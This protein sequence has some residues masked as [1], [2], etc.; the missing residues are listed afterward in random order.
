[1]AHPE[2]PARPW[3]FD[4]VRA[5]TPDGIRPAR[6]VVAGASVAAVLGPSDPVP[7]G[8]EVIRGG[9]HL[10]L[11]AFCDAHC[12]FLFVGLR[13]IRPDLEP[14][15]S[16][17]EALALLDAASRRSDFPDTL[18]AEAWDESTWT[19][20]RRP[21]T[22]E[23]LDRVVPDRPVVARRVCTHFATANSAALPYFEGEA[24][25]D[26]ATG[27]LLEGPAMR[28]GVRL[29]G[30]EGERDR[31]LDAAVAA[32]H[33]AGIGTV[34]DLSRRT[35][36]S[37]FVAA[38]RAGR[39]PLRVRFFVKHEEWDPAPDWTEA[40]TPAAGDGVRVVGVKLFAD[41]SFGARSAAVSEPFAGTTE[42]GQLLWAAPALTSALRRI[43]DAGLLPAVHA[44]G[45][46]AVGLV[47]GA[48]TEA[49][50]SRIRVEHLE[51]VDEATTHALAGV[52]AIAS[53]Q[54]NFVSRWAGS[55]G[56]YEQVL[57]PERAR[58][59][60]PFRRVVD[61]GLPLAFGSDS[62]PLGPL[63]GIPGALDHPDP[64]QRLSLT[65]TLHA[66]TRGGPA[67]VGEAGGELRPGA[68]ADLTWVDPGPDLAW[69]DARVLGTWV[70]GRRVYDG[71]T[72]PS[73]VGGRT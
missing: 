20:D 14:A 17:D 65:E 63:V 40:E 46:R 54:P 45:D 43:A 9:G 8:A 51:M 6:V 39:L 38:D 71:W 72:E 41:G 5:L 69:Q 68:R 19:G 58:A 12:H 3:V 52:G 33:R 37:T 73:G 13:R 49:A 32:A 27:H 50:L 7:E 35:D 31:A 62:M 60:N 67:S 11:P 44:I 64:G 15:R 10:L 23:D 66:Y 29:P 70:G 36:L 1:M 61:Q 18:L 34:H 47:A 59:T 48:A 53:M 24:G 4:D 42:H 22:R 30:L 57:G 55:Q 25:V 26:P 21:L 2:P 16:R 56:L 28:A